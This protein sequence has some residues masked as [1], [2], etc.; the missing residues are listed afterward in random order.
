MSSKLWGGRFT[1][2]TDPLMEKF[3]ASIDFDRKLWRVDIAG[4]Q[5]YARALGQ[6]GILAADEVA[7]LVD[8]LDQVAAEW[9]AGTFVLHA[10]DEDIHTA[11]ERRLTELIGA[12]AG[13]LHTGRSRNDQ[14]ATDVRLWLR[15]EITALRGHLHDLMRVAVDQAEQEID[16]LMP[17]H[18]H[19]AGQPIA[20]AS[21]C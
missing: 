12:V 17:A 9:E 18:P 21:G 8:G 20:G 16:I 6:A 5:A 19:A 14:I 4:S 3:N 10:S 2:A 11:N 13:K 7:A 15:A 1:G